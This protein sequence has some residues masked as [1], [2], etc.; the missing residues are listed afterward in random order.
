V[1]ALYFCPIFQSASNHRYHTHDYYQV[2]PLLGGQA[3]F[4]RLLDEAH[5]RGL[6][7]VLD[8]VFNHASR[9]FFYFNDILENGSASPYVDWFRVTDFPVN[10]YDHG[11]PASYHAWWGLHALPKLNTDHPQV[12][13][14]VLRV[15]EHWL[16]EGIDGWRLDVPQ[17]IHTPGFW[18]EFRARA[19]A[20]NPEVYLV[21]EIWQ[22]AA[23]WLRGDRFD[24]V[25]NYPFAEAALGFAGGARVDARLAEG[26]GYRPQA[27]LDGRAFAARLEWLWGLYPWEITLTQLNLLDSHDTARAITLCGG[28]EASVRLATLLLLTAPGAPCI[29]YGDEIG[30]EGGVPDYDTRRP[31]PWHRPETWNRATL[32]YHRALIALRRG[33]AA[34]RRGTYHNLYADD[35][36]VAFGRRFGDEAAIV[37]AN[38]GEAARSVAVP[39]GAL[40]GEGRRWRVVFPGSGWGEVEGQADGAVRLRVEGRGGVVLAAEP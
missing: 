9:G 7:V 13:E 20:V 4:R 25:M 10:A 5:R 12:R 14:Y 24:G 19:K 28:D 29:Y 16:R 6:R 21:G 37:V 35:G 26:K 2:D 40:A 15:A 30:L 34:L 27:A 36:C 33:H 3:A 39:V 22:P 32:E 11:R 23:D 8:G 38:A 17:E 31:F 1:T 18:E